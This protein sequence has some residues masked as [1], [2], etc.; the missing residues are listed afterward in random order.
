MKVSAFEH[1]V[2]LYIFKSCTGSIKKVD[3]RKSN[4][5]KI[6][7]NWDCQVKRA[8]IYLLWLAEKQTV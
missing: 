8:C 1:S 3:I 4:D 5:G 2:I 7:E 6:V